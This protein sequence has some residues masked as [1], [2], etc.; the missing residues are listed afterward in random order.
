VFAEKEAQLDPAAGKFDPNVRVN[1]RLTKGEQMHS[2]LAQLAGEFTE[3]VKSY[4]NV[5]IR[6]LEVL[7]HNPPLDIRTIHTRAIDD[8]Y[9]WTALCQFDQGQFQTA[10]DNLQKYRKRPEPGNWMRESLY[11]LALSLAAAGDRAAAIKELEAVESDDPEYAG[12]R[13]LIRQW[14]A[15]G[16]NAER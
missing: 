4:T 7:R 11:L 12:Y 2:R 9:F 5:R 8:A 3:A 1:V 10:A 14:R 15:A 16:V 13:L 6:C